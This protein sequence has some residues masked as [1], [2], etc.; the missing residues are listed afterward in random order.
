MYGKDTRWREEAGE[1]VRGS[2]EEG[3]GRGVNKAG[4]EIKGCGKAGRGDG[5]RRGPKVGS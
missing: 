2:D 3:R 1:R 4:S 5:L